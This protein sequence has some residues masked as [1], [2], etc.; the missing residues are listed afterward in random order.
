MQ[1]V[2][3]QLQSEFELVIYDT[4]ILTGF[5]DA[6][7]LATATDGLVLVTGVGKLKRSILEETIEKLKVS[8]TPLLGIVVNGDKNLSVHLYQ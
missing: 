3:E 6:H 5:T 4:T 8:R 7:L 2:M 1:H